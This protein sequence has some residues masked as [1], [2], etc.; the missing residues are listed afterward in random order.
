MKVV[1][2]IDGPAASGKSTVARAVARELGFVWLNTGAFYRGAT[3][4]FLE[5]CGGVPAEEAVPGLLEAAGFSAEVDGG[6]AHMRAGGVDPSPFTRSPEVN[7]AVSFV[8]RHAAVRAALNAIFRGLGGEHA[9]VAEGRDVGSVIFPATPFKFYI[10][11][12]PEE[13]ER[14]RRAE[15]GQDAIAERDRLDSQR[16]SAPLAVAEGARVI[17][18]TGLTPAEVVGMVL[19]ALENGGV[20]RART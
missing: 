17:D 12:T 15:G 3:W 16:A 19:E 13:R 6:A 4:W 7:A 10:D 14:R 18:S 8:S 9:L 11:A 1:V 5:K 2:A 20:P